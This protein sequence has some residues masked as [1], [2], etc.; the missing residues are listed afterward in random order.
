MFRKV[1]SAAI[2]AAAFTALYAAGAFATPGSGFTSVDVSKG[3][4]ASTSKV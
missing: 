3:R 4:G 2:L 1:R